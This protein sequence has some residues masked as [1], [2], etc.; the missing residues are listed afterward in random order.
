[1]E[2]RAA[3]KQALGNIFKRGA[4]S[5]ITDKPSFPKPESGFVIGFNH[6]SLGEI[7]RLM[8]ICMLTYPDNDYLF[9]VNVVWYEAL[10]PIIPRLSNFGFTLMPVITPSAR[11]TLLKHSK[12]IAAR[13]QVNRLA[14]GFANTYMD[15]SAE[16][17]NDGQIV[18][19]APSATR[20]AHL[21]PNEKVAKGQAP[22]EPQTMTLLAMRLIKEKVEHFA[23]IPVAVVAPEGASRGLNLLDNY[24]IIP[25]Y[26]IS[27]D[28]VRK[29]CQEREPNCDGRCFERYFLDAI[30]RALK[31]NGA[32][33]RIIGPD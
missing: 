26:A 6:P 12:K 9:P 25:W 7:I 11:Q 3:L 2:R 23:F 29:K 27:D 5:T 16:F 1:M 13:V 28:M 33:N 8:G 19:V 14:R 18:L 24:T 10:A 32:E 4:P 21:Y 15:R 31:A 20:K 17:V 30:A 22:I